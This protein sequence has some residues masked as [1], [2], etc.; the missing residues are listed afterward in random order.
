MKAYSCLSVGSVVLY[1]NEALAS[2]AGETGANGLKISL[3]I[4]MLE[5]LY[6]LTG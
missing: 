1:I 5:S 4:E 2:P 3:Y 6:S